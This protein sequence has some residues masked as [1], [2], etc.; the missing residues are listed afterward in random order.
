MTLEELWRLFPI[1]LSAYDPRWAA[2]YSD[3][4]ER[5]QALL[6]DRIAKIDHIGSTSVE[7][8]LAKPIVDILLQVAPDA[9]RAELESLLLEDGWLVM[10]KDPDRGKLDLN[11]GYTPKGFAERVYHLHVRGKGDW[12]E[13]YFRDYLADHPKAQ[14]E[15]SALKRR[16]IKEYQYDRDAYTEAKTD[17]VKACATK[18]REEGL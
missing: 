6:G 1:Q 13:L 5:L 10:A 16:L 12:D 2:W 18:A 11:K 8:M 3:E 17:F 4:C 7:G 14:E 15:Y 9:D